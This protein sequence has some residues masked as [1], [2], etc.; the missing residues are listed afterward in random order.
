MLKK[1]RKLKPNIRAT[2][3]YGRN[4]FHHAAAAGNLLGIQFTHLYMN[5]LHERE[6]KFKIPEG[7]LTPQIQQ[8]VAEKTHGGITS[9]M[10]AA[11][12]LSSA[13]V[14]YLLSIGADPKT[15]DRQG[16]TAKQYAIA[17]CPRN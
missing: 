2:D 10:K 3:K 16:R 17:A 4:A 1:L 7:Y 11:M 8:L 6:T 5:Y 12:S 15:T 9:L 14:Q 13:T